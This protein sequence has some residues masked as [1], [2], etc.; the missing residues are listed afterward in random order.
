MSEARE[1]LRRLL[2]EPFASRVPPDEE[3]PQWVRSIPEGLVDALLSIDPPRLEGVGLALAALGEASAGVLAGAERRATSRPARKALRRAIHA[4]RSRGVD[5][6]V[7]RP[8]GRGRFRPAEEEGDQGEGLVGRIGPRGERLLLWLPLR[9]GGSTLY[10][11]LASDETGVIRV[12]ALRGS[13]SALRRVAREIRGRSSPPLVRTTASAAR[14]LLRRLVAAG[15][16]ERGE[17]ASA[18][19]AELARSADAGRTPGE[20]VRERLAGRPMSLAFAAIELRARIERGEIATWL[21][22]GEAIERGAKELED[23]ERSPIVLPPAQALRR[24]AE[25]MERAAAAAFA[26][27]SRERLAARLEETAFVL[28]AR[29][30]EDGARAALAVAEQ[31]RSAPDPSRVEFLR[32]LLEIS[33]ER[34]GAEIRKSAKSASVLAP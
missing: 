25:A 10:E 22:G 33:L 30:D 34:V 19:E 12:E 1:R 4:L 24:R 15:V 13:R 6:A 7:A 8:E 29:S 31:V 9:P 21:L 27:D 17:A 5:V 20:E 16:R 32:L 23:I 18:L 26:K 28:Y 2:P 14:E 3:L 11:V